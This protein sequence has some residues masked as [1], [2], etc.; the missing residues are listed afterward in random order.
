MSSAVPDPY[1][2]LGVGRDA[3]NL[4]IRAA[5]RRLVA[6]YHP[7][8]HQGNPLED[9]ASARMAEVNQAYAI[10]SNPALRAAHDGPPRP[11]VAGGRGRASTDSAGSGAGGRLVKLAVLV[12]ALPLIVRLAG[13]V[14]RLVAGLAR[15]AASGTGLIRGTGVAVAVAFVIGAALLWAILRRRQR[16]RRRSPTAPSG[17]RP[18]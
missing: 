4:E 12:V 10:L 8:R 15:S 3:T 9:L 5:Y 2:V 14:G 17:R 6:R 18:R 16:R 11:D 13:G 1:V 7:D